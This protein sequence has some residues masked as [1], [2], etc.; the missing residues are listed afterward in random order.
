MSHNY[1]WASG[2]AFQKSIS[3]SS[4]FKICNVMH[5]IGEESIHTRNFHICD[6]LALPIWESIQ[7]SL[8]TKWLIPCPYY[9]DKTEAQR[10]ER[11]WGRSDGESE[12]LGLPPVNRFRTMFIPS[13]QRSLKVP[14][15]A[16]K[17]NPSLVPVKP[18]PA[19]SVAPVSSLSRP[20]EL[21]TWAM[22]SP[23]V[24]PSSTL[25]TTLT[26]IVTI[27]EEMKIF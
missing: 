3:F 10:E 2:F 12:K 18:P 11:P 13:V 24:L 6:S 22:G 25:I 9:N 16:T 26:Y 8:S 1:R 17:M 15:S 19:C 21:N 20:R 4:C 23:W 14:G 27:L 5:L 7:D